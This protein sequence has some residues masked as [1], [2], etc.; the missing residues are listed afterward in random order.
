MSERPTFTMA[1]LAAIRKDWKV[2]WREEGKLYFK[3]FKGRRPTEAVEF[4][5]SLKRRGILVV[6]VVSMSRAFPPPLH[7]L[8]PDRQGLLWCPYCI[9]WREFKEEGLPNSPLL[10][11]MRCPTCSISIKDAYVRT[12]NPEL[13]LRIELAAEIKQKRKEAARLKK[14]E[15]ARLGVRG[16]LKSR[17]RRR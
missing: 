7:K 5:K 6:D 8:K 3:T 16:G 1:E 14:K 13:V 12:Y 11:Y 9:K 10:I 17:R 4:G 2:F 15:G